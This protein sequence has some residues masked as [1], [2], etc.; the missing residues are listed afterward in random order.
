M[1]PVLI[2]SIRR[3]RT[4]LTYP[5]Y[6]GNVG[7]NGVREF[8]NSSSYIK[9][10]CISVT[11][12]C[13]HF[14]PLNGSNYI[15]PLSL[16][17]IQNRLLSTEST[18]FSPMNWWR[19]RQEKKEEQKYRQRIS[20]MAEMETW[21]IGMMLHEIDEAA[22]SWTAKLVSNK[23]TDA[24]KKMQKTLTGIV[25]IV[26]EDATHDKLTNMSRK[27]KLEA[28][29]GGETS[30]EE[31]NI[32]AAQFQTMSLMHRVLRKR[33]QEGKSIPETPEAMQSVL[34]ADGIKFL[35][36]D[37]KQKLAKQHARMLTRGRR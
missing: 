14:R 8:Q 23:E 31:V 28:A 37:Q 6:Q 7:I 27:E 4:L 1:L 17:T 33:K 9:K 32:M 15:H 24:V 10:S 21:T 13:L 18:S 30:V 2:N 36:K 35:T 11:L 22:S 20:G 12:R 26:G 34:Q 19:G 29:L 5:T 25:K 3:S 16:K